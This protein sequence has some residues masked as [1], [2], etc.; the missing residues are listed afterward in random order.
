MFGNE[1]TV[2]KKQMG[3]VRDY[4]LLACCFTFAIIRVVGV[5]DVAM[6]LHASHEHS[7]VHGAAQQKR[8]ATTFRTISAQTSG[9]KAS[10]VG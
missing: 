4:L 9:A 1:F 2:A 7:V 10:I 8:N 5:L 3:S 6:S